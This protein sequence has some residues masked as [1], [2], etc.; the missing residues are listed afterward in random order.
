MAVD[1][2]ELKAPD[3]DTIASL[4]VGDVVRYTSHRMVRGV[5]DYAGS[6]IDLFSTEQTTVVGRVFRLAP[7]GGVA[8]TA[9]LA[10]DSPPDDDLVFIDLQDA[11]GTLEVLWRAKRLVTVSLDEFLALANPPWQERVVLRVVEPGAVHAGNEPVEFTGQ[12]T[13]V[14]HDIA[15]TQIELDNARRFLV[16]YVTHVTYELGGLVRP[17]EQSSEQVS[18]PKPIFKKV[19]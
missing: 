1:K 4:R 19:K 11:N 9:W 3:R 15:G 7:L 10:I 17:F 6:G 16:K 2:V 8:N 18:S 5:A 12:F 14:V 13:A